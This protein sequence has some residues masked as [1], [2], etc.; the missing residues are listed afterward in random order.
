MPPASRSLIL[1]EQVRPTRLGPHASAPSSRCVG[2]THSL[3]QSRALLSMPNP[4][5]TTPPLRGL[6]RPLPFRLR[7]P[8]E[9]FSE[10]GPVYP[11]ERQGRRPG[12]A[13]AALVAR[14]DGRCAIGSWL[15]HTMACPGARKF[16]RRAHKVENNKHTAALSQLAGAEE[17]PHSHRWPRS[18]RPSLVGVATF[19][20]VMCNFGC[21]R[22]PSQVREFADCPPLTRSRRQAARRA[23]CI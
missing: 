9:N 17:R 11:C 21:V 12:A 23:S 13:S 4:V 3:V 6:C 5:P 22:W 14:C 10:V 20:V 16:R 2:G 15:L 19:G 8:L 7:G 1:W 18:R